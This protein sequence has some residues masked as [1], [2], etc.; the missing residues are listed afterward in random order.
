MRNVKVERL[1]VLLVADAVGGV[2]D[3]ALSLAGGLLGGDHA[4]VLLVSVGP[5]PDESR[6]QSVRCIPGLELEVLDGRLEWMEDGQNWLQ[7]FRSQVVHLAQQWRATLVHVNQLGLAAIEPAD[8]RGQPVPVV[9]GVHSDLVTWWKWVKHGGE[10]PVAIPSY[11]NWQRELGWSALRQ[12]DAVV[13]PSAFLADEIAHAYQL[14][15]SPAV[16]HNGVIPSVSPEKPADRDSRLAVVVG[17]AW[18]EAKN[19]ALVADAM[20]TGELGWH[21]EVAGDLIEPGR[22]A[23]PMH[24]APGLRYLGFLRKSDLA[25]LFRHASLFIA[26]SRYEPFGL[27]AVEAAVEGCAVVANDLPSYREVWG[28]AAVY[29]A[30][31]DPNS[32]TAILQRLAS[33]DEVV[34]R[35]A[36]AARQRACAR[37]TI[38]RMVAQYLNL[39]RRLLW[40]SFPEQTEARL[41]VQHS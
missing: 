33:D 27:A 5:R 20:R 39:Y 3:Y 30:R 7:A 23:T 38:D 21:V 18:D 13:C 10:E 2:W 24:Q 9:L 41:L 1:R 4:D 25:C 15:A 11:L 28:D 12:A 14:E 26:S 36:Q 16:I 40:T 6:L 34:S 22:G 35:L 31:N 29:F 37:Y 19:V 8:H 17:R 32:L